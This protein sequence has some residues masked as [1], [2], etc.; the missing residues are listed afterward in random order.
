MKKFILEYIS[1]IGYIIT[2]LVFSVAVFMLFINFYHY[3][4]VN[5]SYVKNTDSISVYEKN[6][7]KFE[8][9]KNNISVFNA[10]NF[11]TNP[12]NLSLMSSKARIDMCLSKYES[13]S[14]NK[15]FEKKV[16]TAKDDYDLLTNY[17]SDIINDCIVMQ[18][19]GFDIPGTSYDKVKPFIT[20]NSKMLMDDMDYVK[21]SLQNNSTYQFGSNFDKVNVFDLTRDS[22][23]KIEASY[24]DSVDL[25][26]ELSR[27]F[28]N[29]VLG[30]AV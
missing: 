18:V 13:S 6:K 16:I 27:W 11:K 9:I 30:G 23:T 25:L 8:E 15:I 5:E 7:P 12:N 2:G 14:I 3:K 20:T 24:N 17:Q 10:N 22:Y 4:E 21:R 1:I 29:F 19:Y 26:L 28:K